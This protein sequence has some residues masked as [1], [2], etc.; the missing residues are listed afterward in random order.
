MRS[1]DFTRGLTTLVAAGVAGL[2]IW[3]ATLIDRTTDGGFWATMGIIAGAGLVMAVSQL[4]GGWT[5]WGVPRL[6]AATLVLAFLP[7]LVCVG[8]ILLTTQ[9]HGGWQQLRLGGWSG[10]IGIL[11]FVRHVGIYDAVFAFGFGLVFGYSFDTTGNRRHRREAVPVAVAEP[12]VDRRA[13]DEPLAAER[14]TVISNGGEREPA[15]HRGRAEIRHGGVRE[16]G[17]PIAPQPE[18]RRDEPP[19]R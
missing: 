8:W 1:Y 17:T 14:A 16:G 5:K 19:A 11:G 6:S 18:P 4:V 10:S 2:L 9:P 3:V 15:G 7:V 13:A 12:V